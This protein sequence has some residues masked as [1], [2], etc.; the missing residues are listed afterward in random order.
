M[1]KTELQQI[2]K[3]E[4]KNVLKAK[5]TLKEGRGSGPVSKHFKNW[6][7]DVINAA[8]D[9]EEELLGKVD[10]DTMA[11]IAGA[12]QDI[13]DAA[14]EDGIQSANRAGDTYYGTDH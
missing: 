11:V 8:Y 5:K 12:V 9:I 13:V 4:L 10:K 1:N 7:Q 14:W 3:E 2:I 6:S